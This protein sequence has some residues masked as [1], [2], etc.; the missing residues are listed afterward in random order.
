VRHA[1][2][3]QRLAAFEGYFSYA[4]PYTLREHQGHPQVIHSCR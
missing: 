2:D 3:A 4:S 1:P